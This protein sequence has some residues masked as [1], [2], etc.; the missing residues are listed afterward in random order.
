MDQHKQLANARIGPRHQLWRTPLLPGMCMGGFQW[1]VIASP[2][3][4]VMVVAPA[5]DTT[6][7]AILTIPRRLL[8]STISILKPG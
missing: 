5:S 6:V 7:P 1:L 2:L 8:G 3:Y 4:R